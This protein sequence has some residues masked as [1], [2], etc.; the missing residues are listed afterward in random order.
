MP[1]PVGQI[2]RTV[3]ALGIV[4]AVAGALVGVFADEGGR[5]TNL[6][7]APDRID[8]TTVTKDGRL[9]LLQVVPGGAL[10]VLQTTGGRRRAAVERLLQ[11][12]PDLL[13]RR[14]WA[15]H[16]SHELRKPAPAVS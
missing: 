14:T 7:V 5:L 16:P 12:R 9:R 6:R 11:G 13:G 10:N 1:G 15:D 8:A 2:V 4:I 3:I